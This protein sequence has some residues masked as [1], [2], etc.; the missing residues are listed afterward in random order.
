M[1]YPSH[2]GSSSGVFMSSGG[3][4][5]ADKDPDEPMQSGDKSRGAL[6]TTDDGGDGK[7]PAEDWSDAG[8][9]VFVQVSTTVDFISFSMT[10][11]SS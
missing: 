7:D 10:E 1:P 9:T 11:G 5:A 3:R 8:A 2:V 6:E 4:G